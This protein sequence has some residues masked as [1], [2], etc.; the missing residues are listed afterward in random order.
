MRGIYHTNSV[1][2]HGGAHHTNTHKRTRTDRKGNNIVV[3]LVGKLTV[4][5]R[6]GGWGASNTQA[7]RQKKKQIT[8]S[9]AYLLIGKLT[10]LRKLGEHKVEAKAHQTHHNSDRTHAQTHSHRYLLTCRQADGAEAA[11]R[12]RREPLAALRE[13]SEAAHEA[14]FGPVGTA[15]ACLNK[16][17]I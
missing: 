7:H 11:G 4:R 5:A 12:A 10:V 3:L 14:D 13:A 6:G 9:L 1:H 2:S 15:L 8:Y 17:N 16:K